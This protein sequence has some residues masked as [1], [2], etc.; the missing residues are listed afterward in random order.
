MAITKK[1]KVSFDL[2]T[3]M[4]SVTEQKLLAE[5]LGLCKKASKGEKLGPEQR[6]LIVQ[7]LTHGMDGA[8]A[9]IV[10]TSMREGVKEMWEEFSDRDQFKF[11][12]ATVREVY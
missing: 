1:F 9:F 11:S 5:I 4:D 2:T 6:E 12:P 7:F 10:R 8:V 3:K